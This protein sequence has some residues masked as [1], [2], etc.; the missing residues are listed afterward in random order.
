VRITLTVVLFAMLLGTVTFGLSAALSFVAREQRHQELDAENR[1]TASALKLALERSELAVRTE[2]QQAC[3]RDLNLERLALELMLTDADAS[4]AMRTA[5]GL[6]RVIGVP[7]SLVFDRGSELRLLASTQQMPL[8][9]STPLL[10]QS[11]RRAVALATEQEM[12]LLTACQRQL[13]SEAALWVIAAQSLDGAIRELG[14]RAQVALTVSKTGLPS[15]EAALDIAAYRGE[16]GDVIASVTLPRE[17]KP[18][19]VDRSIGLLAGA[20]GMLIGAMLGALVA[21]RER[22]YERSLS[23]LEQAAERVASGDLMS[24]IGLRT[25][26]RADQTFGTFDRMTR[27]L[28]EMRARV[29][30]AER[31]AAF[32]DVAQRIAH[33]IKNPLSPI[34]TAM[35]TLRKADARRLPELP[36]I[37]DESTRAVLDEVRRMERILGEFAAFARLPKAEPGALD[38]AALIR[39]TLALYTP[40]DVRVERELAEGL[41]LVRADRGQITQALVNVLQNAFDAARERPQARV[42]VR[43]AEEDDGV[44]IHVDDSGAGIAKQARERVLEPYFTTKSHG[45]GLGLS[46]V[47]RILSDHGGMLAI[48]ESPLGGA[49]V[50]MKLRYSLSK[51]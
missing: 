38:L 4:G 2:V 43:L 49:R 15:D 36:E 6:S 19:R 9:Y 21:V 37:I 44:A 17:L 16:R 24:S 25:G 23:A 39:D 45:T 10:A 5:Q 40:D 50:T 47:K 51:P 34:K 7:I 31:E 42:C 27:E 12:W 26:D 28:R 32:R 33:E 48:A 29:V 18:E 1:R 8:P 46:I 3:A 35:E 30:A 11:A 20:F 41:E 22:R 14:T 13:G